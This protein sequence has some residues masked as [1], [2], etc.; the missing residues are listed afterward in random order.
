MNGLLKQ[1]FGF[2]IVESIE[3]LISYFINL[4]NWDVISK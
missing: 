1:N 4:V 2:D 3:N